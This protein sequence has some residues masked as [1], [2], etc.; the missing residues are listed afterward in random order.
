MLSLILG[1]VAMH[2]AV[3]CHD[4]AGHAQHTVLHGAVSAPMAMS[5]DGSATVDGGAAALEATGSGS[6]SLGS[7]QSPAAPPLV[8]ARSDVRAISLRTIDVRTIDVRAIDT[9]DPTW[10]SSGHSMMHDLLHLCLAVL[11]ALLALAAAA[12]LAVVVA[13]AGRSDTNR[14]GGRP[15]AG[16]RAPPPT[17]VR[18]AQLCVLRN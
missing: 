17:S 10:P 3:A 6:A 5:L 1:V 11:T 12:L 9:A 8:T 14:R 2:S 4:D 15:V 13:R 7:H 16:P 18:L